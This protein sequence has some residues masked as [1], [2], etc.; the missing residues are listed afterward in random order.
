MRG[1]K[2][3]LLGG[4]DLEMEE[5]RKLLEDQGFN[6]LSKDNYEIAGQGYIDK[7]LTWGASVI[8]YEEF[9]DYTGTIYG[10]ELSEPPDWYKPKNC[11]SYK[12]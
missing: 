4:N 8:D 12:S 7:Q 11:L 2:L 3:F 6:R 10:I 1:K 9:L 5:I